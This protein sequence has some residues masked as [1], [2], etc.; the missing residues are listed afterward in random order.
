MPDHAQPRTRSIP[1]DAARLDALMEQAGL[2][3]LVV[4]SKHNV[5]YLLGGYRFAFFDHKEAIG[6]SRYL[7]V[8]IYP[9]GR[10]DRAAYVAARLESF[11]HQLDRFWMEDVRTVSWGTTDAMEA[12]VGRL[13]GLGLPLRRI[14]IEPSFLPFDAATLLRDALPETEWVDAVVPLE[15]LRARKTAAELELLRQASERV[16]AAM[17]QAFAACS[18]G[19]TKR[20]VVDV[21][22]RAEVERGLTFEYCL[23]TAG[24]S[25]NRAVSDQVIA[26]GDIVSLDSGGNYNGYI[27]DLCRMG[28]LGE[29]DAELQDLLAEVEAVQQAARR[30]LRAGATGDEVYAAAEAAVAASPNRAQMHFLAH[31]MGLVA[32]EAPRL[33]G[34]GFV[35]YSGFDAKRPLDAG[36]VVSIETEIRHPRRGFIKLEDTVAVTTTGCEGFGDAARGW[37]R[38]GLG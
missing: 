37:N 13:R 34:C 6:L 21:L 8:L 14:G 30:P 31:G 22:R 18:P 11:E 20:A 9:R 19:M 1:F 10:P 33:T 3:A 36:M 2:D 17:Q 7:P 26:A 32:H 24:T 35:P 25:L 38:A 23:I 5:Q 28:V 29:P 4:T 27:G 15:R 12:A 16:V